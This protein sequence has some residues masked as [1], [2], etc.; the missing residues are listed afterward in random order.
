MLRRGLRRIVCTGIFVLTDQA[1]RDKAG[2]APVLSFVVAG[3]ACVF[4]AL[5]ELRAA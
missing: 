1:A 5:C 3:A 2:Y 4:A